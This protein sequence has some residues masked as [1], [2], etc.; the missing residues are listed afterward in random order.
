[1]E[2]DFVGLAWRRGQRMLPASSGVHGICSLG[3]ERRW[4]MRE[5]PEVGMGKT[6]HLGDIREEELRGEEVVM[7]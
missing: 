5:P 6:W 7:K 4:Q 3:V 1:M 2:L